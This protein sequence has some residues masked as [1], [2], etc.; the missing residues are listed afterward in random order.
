ME[1]LK[2]NIRIRV[3]HANALAYKADVLV[4]KFAQELYGLDMQV[5]DRL[6]RVGVE[7]LSHLPREGE[8][9]LVNSMNQIGA[10]S[11]LFV[12]VKSLFYFRYQEIR[13]FARRT[14]AILAKEAPETKHICLTLHG[15]NYGLDEVEAFVSEIAGLVDALNTYDFPKKLELITIVELNQVRTERLQNLLSEL[16]PKGYFEKIAQRSKEGQIQTT[17]ER[18][19]SAGHTSDS[20]PHVFVAMPFADEMDDVYDYGIRGVIN[21]AGF[22]CER[23]DLSAF[24]GDILEWV[25]KRIRTSAFVLADLTGAN[26]NVYL[27]VGYAWGCGVP[28]ILIVHDAEELKFDVQGQRC[29][30]YKRIKELEES[31]YKELESLRKTLS[32]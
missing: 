32:V 12:G 8:H 10:R 25:K 7:T 21:D 31:L 28:T 1:T 30:V 20:K 17:D 18:L 2:K 9:H 14:L 13:E 23:A 16:L 5:V 19:Q 26:S 22:I 11:I 4:L 15:A 27:E 3:E 6:E 29:L 24:T